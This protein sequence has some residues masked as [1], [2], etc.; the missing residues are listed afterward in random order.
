MLCFNHAV[1]IC[2]QSRL[3]WALVQVRDSTYFI[4]LME[5]YQQLRSDTCQEQ[6]RFK[7]LCTRKDTCIILCWRKKTGAVLWKRRISSI[8]WK[9]G[10]GNYIILNEIAGFFTAIIFFISLWNWEN[11]CEKSTPAHITS[12]FYHTFI[13]ILQLRFHR[14][15][16]NYSPGSWLGVNAL[17]CKMV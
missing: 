17:L 10:I 7:S 15:V 3:K 4:W 16:S 8:E 6:S 1:K 9:M 11:W 14:F 12:W 13:Y 5:L 2:K